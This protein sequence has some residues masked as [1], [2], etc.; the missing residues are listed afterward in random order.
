MNLGE[1][2]LVG[3]CVQWQKG[4]REKRGKKSEGGQECEGKAL[5]IVSA[6]VQLYIPKGIKSVVGEYEKE[7]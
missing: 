4:N 2:M 1:Y 5:L 3:N 6:T 7:W